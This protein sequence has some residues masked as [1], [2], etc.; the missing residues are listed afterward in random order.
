MARQLLCCVAE[1]VAYI[2]LER[3]ELGMCLL[4]ALQFT[5]EAV[6]FRVGSPHDFAAY[7]YLVDPNACTLSKSLANSVIPSPDSH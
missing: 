1:K 7:E 2:I 5:I 4:Q 6:E 3:C